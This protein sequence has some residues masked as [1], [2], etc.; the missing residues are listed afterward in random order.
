MVRRGNGTLGVP[1]RCDAVFL[2]DWDDARVELTISASITSID[3]AATGVGGRALLMSMLVSL[4][5]GDMSS[6]TPAC[7]GDAV[8]FV[9]TLVTELGLL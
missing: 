1:F 2:R 3:G 6:N 8:V 4:D 7:T 9:S 5:R